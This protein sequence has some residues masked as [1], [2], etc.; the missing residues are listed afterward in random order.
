L[1][2][3]III[4]D[5][6]LAN[7]EEGTFDMAFIDADK[8][9]YDS[10]YEK[11][12]KLLRRGGVIAIDNVSFDCTSLPVPCAIVLLI[13]DISGIVEWKSDRRDRRR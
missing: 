7:G 5:S 13:T 3:L 12:L 11:S 4:I 2:I 10:Y 9:N 1:I 6:L 8:V